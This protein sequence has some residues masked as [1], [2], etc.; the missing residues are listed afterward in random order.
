MSIL[1]RTDC[2]YQVTPRR[3]GLLQRPP[4]IIRMHQIRF[5]GTESSRHFPRPLVRW[6]KTYPSH[7]RCPFY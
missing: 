1:F 5:A 7:A 4:D 6:V 2:K 3:I